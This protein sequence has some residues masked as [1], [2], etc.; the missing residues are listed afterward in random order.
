[1]TSPLFRSV[2]HELTR[3]GLR[4]SESYSTTAI[5]P[6]DVD[7]ATD[8]V[9]EAAG[10]PKRG[11]PHPGNPSIVVTEVRISRE[12]PNT[13][14]LDYI[15]DRPENDIFPQNTDELGFAETAFSA[16]PFGPSA[17]LAT[18]FASPVNA[19]T[20]EIDPS[21]NEPTTDPPTIINRAL[22]TFQRA[23]DTLVL[24]AHRIAFTVTGTASQ[25][26]IGGEF[27][28]VGLVPVLTQLTD[29]IHT[30]GAFALLFNGV[31]LAWTGNRPEGRV[32]TINYEWTYEPG[33]L[34]VLPDGWSQDPEVGPSGQFITIT[35]AIGR[36]STDADG[37]K[38]FGVATPSVPAPSSIAGR[39][40]V[41]GGV[42]R[43]AVPPYCDTSSN[44]DA[45]GDFAVPFFEAIPRYVRVDANE[46]WRNFP[47]IGAP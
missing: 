11:D 33:Q 24:R 40:H 26:G 36:F 39:G 8:A 34:T 42:A 14:R 38:F 12:S 32:Y 20:I 13:A 6:N 19:E 4:R 16:I 15:Y 28:D 43:Y 30:I 18:A 35:N 29:T 23:D 31:D 21:T 10:F 41:L 37:N 25:L 7:S 17:K 9:L 45:S 1:M 22:P 2:F 44:V 3:S 47:G 46:E 27:G 5:N